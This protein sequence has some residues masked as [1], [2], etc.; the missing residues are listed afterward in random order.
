MHTY[1][2]ILIRAIIAILLLLIMANILGKQTISNM[3][4][5]DFVTSITIG[6]IAANLAFN[7]KLK[8]THMVLALIVM[9]ITSVLLSVIALKSR[10]WR[11]WISGS[12][13]VLIE[14]GKILEGNMKKVRY[15]LD[16]LDQAL[17]E[18]G[19]FNMGEVEYAVLEDNGVLS[20]LKKD[21][22]QFVTKRDL[23]LGGGSLSFPIELIMD[24]ALMEQNLTMNGLTREWLE[25]ELRRR[26]KR[27]ED[28]FYAVRGTHKQLF[29]D[30]YEDRIRQP[31]DKE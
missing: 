19:I 30:Y 13:T 22:Y 27:I 20:I 6:A 18:K 3:T 2:D 10:K 25:N 11:N 21:D 24:G 23:K 8:S 12:P 31:V 9:G 28:V 14:G 29:F 26:G 7:T 16:S 17:R 4:F 1:W 5:L 15:T